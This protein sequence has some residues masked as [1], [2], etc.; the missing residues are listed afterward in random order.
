MLSI[1]LA[2][3]NLLVREGVR[4]VLSS[5]EGLQVVAACADADELRIAIKEYEPDVVVTDIH[6][7]PGLSDEG[8]QVAREL[9]RDM[10]HIGVVVLSSRDDP[11]HALDLLE[12][13][14]AGRAYLLKERVAEPGQL[15]NAVFEVARGGSVID[16]QVVENLVRGGSRSPGS[17][18]DK[19]TPREMEVLGEMAQGRTNSAIAQRLFLTVRGVERHINALF[20]KLGMS[21][22]ADAH[23]RVRAV[24]LYLSEH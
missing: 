22:D 9:R 7:P 16:P 20:A 17:T 18:L 15:L 2:E 10:P 4:G 8:I 21:A 13:G 23:H 19:L 14:S 5:G 3:D 24:L 1:V 6:M 12:H 11:Q